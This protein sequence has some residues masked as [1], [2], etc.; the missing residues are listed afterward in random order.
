MQQR[1]GDC[2]LG[3]RE[4]IGQKL[5]F[6]VFKRDNFTCQY[7]G[8]HP[9]LVR[10]EV[11]H[12]DPVAKGGT[13]AIDNLVTSCE[14]C[15]RGKGDRLAL[16]KYSPT[17]K[18]VPWERTL[19]PP[20]GLK[21]FQ[22]AWFWNLLCASFDQ[23]QTQ[24]YL[25]I[26]SS[27]WKVAGAHR[28]DFWENHKSEVM[29]A[30]E[31]RRVENGTAVLFFPPLIEVMQVQVQR[32]RTKKSAGS[33]LFSTVRAGT[34]SSPSQTDFD[35]EVQHQ[36]E[37]VPTEGVVYEKKPVGAA[38]ERRARHIENAVEAARKIAAGRVG[39]DRGERE[40]RTQPRAAGG[41]R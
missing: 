31:V 27:L 38:A 39:S 6:K 13:N 34:F 2:E 20:A 1:T 5:R 30:F 23:Q 8:G 21:D 33:P 12:I 25:P 11:D 28:R 40:N 7:C 32:L 26:T 3:E 17:L 10:L 19:R 18:W 14:E 4:P 35:F 16:D 41:V 36:G 29:T 37:S 15:N 9:P 24:G 22:Q